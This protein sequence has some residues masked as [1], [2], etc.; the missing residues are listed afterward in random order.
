[1]FFACELFLL[2]LLGDEGKINESFRDV[3]KA[4]KPPFK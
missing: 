2:E 4:F 1:M 3:R